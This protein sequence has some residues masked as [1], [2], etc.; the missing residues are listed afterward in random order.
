MAKKLREFVTEIADA[1]RTASNT[2]DSVVGTELAEKIATL[3]AVP[4]PETC[5]TLNLENIE[6]H[7]LG[8]TTDAQSI[9]IWVD[10]RSVFGDTETANQVE[11]ADRGVT[12]F[13]VNSGDEYIFAQDFSNV[14]L[15]SDIHSLVPLFT[16][17]VDEDILVE[18]IHTIA[19][20]NTRINYVFAKNVP[21]NLFIRLDNP[22]AQDIFQEIQDGNSNLVLPEGLFK[23]R[24][25]G[26]LY[27]TPQLELSTY[28]ITQ[29][30]S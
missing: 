22:L 30:E 2:T 16:P 20:E 6:Y 27:Q 25:D 9:H 19:P 5:T 29:Q 23:I 4:E 15:R 21:F 11:S 13:V 12:D 1:Y 10:G 26:V 24:V 8:V 17:W 18:W 7:E 3:I 14:E 28:A